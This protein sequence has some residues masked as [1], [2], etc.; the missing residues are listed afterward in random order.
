MRWQR[1]RRDRRR[2]RRPSCVR[3]NL[4]SR[5]RSLRSPPWRRALSLS[6][7]CQTAQPPYVFHRRERT[8]AVRCINRDVA[9]EFALPA[10]A[11]IE[12]LLLVVEKLLARL[13]RK[14]IVR[15]LD[16][17]IDRA[18]FLAK[19]AIDALHHIDIV[20]RRAPR[21]VVAAGAR[22]DGDGLRRADRLAQLAGDAP[23]LPIGVAAQRVFAAQARA[24]V[25]TLEGVVDGRFRLEKVTQR[26]DGGGH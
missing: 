10:C 5:P 9:R 24:A 22:L 25:V 15:A 26:Q 7:R 2:Q 12:E 8:S 6:F 1:R 23:L 17:G 4:L 19:A 16:D 3:S 14:L 20:T 21:A 11:V 13:D 18:R